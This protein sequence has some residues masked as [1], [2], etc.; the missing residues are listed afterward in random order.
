MY[1]FFLFLG[2]G[3]SSQLFIN[4]RLSHSRVLCQHCN[5]LLGRYLRRTNWIFIENFNIHRVEPTRY[6]DYCGG[7]CISNDHPHHQNIIMKE[8]ICR[9]VTQTSHEIKNDVFTV[10][11]YNVIQGGVPRNNCPRSVISDGPNAFKSAYNDFHRSSNRTDLREDVGANVE[12]STDYDDTMEL[13]HNTFHNE[14]R[15]HPSTSSG[16]YSREIIF[17][18]WIRTRE[19]LFGNERPPPF[20]GAWP[21]TSLLTNVYVSPPSVD[22]VMHDHAYSRASARASAQTSVP[23]V[24]ETTV[25][26]LFI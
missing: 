8:R 12:I 11:F 26:F 18:V 16:F 23:N 1:S 3:S 7:N 10:D 2:A 4:V 20:I 15:Q 5:T 6:L 19:I 14:L 9:S 22:V 13:L 24:F 25:S 17:N 21:P